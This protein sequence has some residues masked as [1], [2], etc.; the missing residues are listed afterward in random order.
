[1]WRGTG[2]AHLR[3]LGALSFAAL[4]HKATDAATASCQQPAGTTHNTAL[5]W[6]LGAGSW[7]LG[8]LENMA[9]KVVKMG[10]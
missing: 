4:S 5:C 2:L 7:E 3:T 1:M 9:L 10:T 6:V 8:E